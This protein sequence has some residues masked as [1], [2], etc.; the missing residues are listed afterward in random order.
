MAFEVTGMPLSVPVAPAGA[1]T[2]MRNG[3]VVIGFRSDLPSSGGAQLLTATYDIYGAFVPGSI[4]PIATS[5]PG[6]GSAAYAGITD[7]RTTQLA[8][9]T[10]LFSWQQ[11]TDVFNLQPAI[12][13]RTYDPVSQ[14]GSASI[15]T[16]SLD[17]G[18]AANYDTSNYGG[19]AATQL[20][21]GSIVIAAAQA[22]QVNFATNA[23]E[24]L[25]QVRTTG[26]T[27]S[28][29]S[30]LANSTFTGN[31]TD[32]DVAAL[33]SDKFVVA[34]TDEAALGDDTSG[35]AVRA[36]VFNSSMAG[37]TAQLLVNTTTAGSQENASVA[38]LA[39]G[40]FVVAWQERTTVGNEANNWGIRFQRFAADGQKLG[41][42]TVVNTTLAG[43]QTRPDVR[44]LADGSFVVAWVEGTGTVK[45]RG[46]AADG[47]ALQNEVTVGTSALAT[48]IPNVVVT[49]DGRVVVNWDTAN[50]SDARVL[51]NRP[52]QLYGTTGNDAIYGHD[53]GHSQVHDIIVL[54][55]GNDTAFGVGGNDYVYGG[56]GADLIYGNEG[57]DVLLGEDGNDSIAGGS[58]QDYLFGGTGANLMLGEGGVDVIN[59]TSTAD[60]MHGGDGGDYF[61]GT[62]GMQTGGVI[63]HG[64]AGNDIFVFSRGE[65]NTRG[66]TVFGDD[67]QDY[68][69]MADGAD[70]MYGGAGVDVMQGGKGMDYY[71]GGADVDY[72]FL[73]AGRQTV[74]MGLS[75]GVDVVNN[76]ETGW[77]YIFLT[78]T[79][80][81]NFA[82]VQA[83][84]TDYGS[85]S[86]ITIDANTAIWL[87]GV[88]PNQMQ[89][90]DFFFS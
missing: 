13:T 11:S 31:Q 12:R 21:G 82:Q 36:R 81:R 5:S 46:F 33:P 18:G 69:Y 62:Y 20:T 28:T 65:G 19:Y 34:W 10:V 44:A 17:P 43:D 26:T 56:A 38:A 57:V 83:A 30:D 84:T 85:F 87:I 89:S 42:E 70:S 61:Y 58:E 15:T 53:I 4:V 8:D 54:G 22:S 14:T 6:S 48:A 24:I 66:D 67:G 75:S 47:T 73:G 7:I 55:V 78:G 32:P 40:E 88:S 80:L 29:T 41:G 3:T 72:L 9:G 1:T 49:S 52:Y 27:T 90:G 39:G 79:P 76:F 60:T 64:D 50:G 37:Q 71:D 68:F 25:V 77:D 45:A 74:V 51:D 23:R 16:L 63:A 86:V 2:W 35:S 59:S